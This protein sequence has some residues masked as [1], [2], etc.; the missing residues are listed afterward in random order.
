MRFRIYAYVHKN[1]RILLSLRQMDPPIDWSAVEARYPLDQITELPILHRVRG[2]FLIDIDK[3]MRIFGVSGWLPITEISSFPDATNNYKTIFV[4]RRKLLIVT[5]YSHDERLIIFSL[6]RLETHPVDW[7]AIIARYSVGTVIEGMIT[8]L[9]RRGSI[10]D[11]EGGIIGWLPKSELSWSK[12][13]K[14][15]NDLLSVGHTSRFVVI[16]DDSKRRSLILSVRRFEVNPLNNVNEAA[17]IG[18]TYFGL[19]VEVVSF[20]VFVRLPIGINGLLHSS[21]M[22]KDL[23]LSEGDAVSVRVLALDKPSGRIGL[24][25]VGPNG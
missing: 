23:L 2:G 19:V 10:V 8:W 14:I 24:R 5:G 3:E 13:G 9:G 20:G 16:G 1:R 15:S 18:A 22:P 7:P 11:L 12:G 17:F 25:Y 4:G 6:R 21:E